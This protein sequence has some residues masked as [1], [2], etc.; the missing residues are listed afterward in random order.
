MAL[1]DEAT[2]KAEIANAAVGITTAFADDTDSGVALEI[3]DPR[4]PLRRV[5]KLIT[6]NEFGEFSPNTDFIDAAYLGKNPSVGSSLDKVAK[7]SEVIPSDFVRQYQLG[8][9]PFVGL[10]NGETQY[11]SDDLPDHSIIAMSYQDA[12]GADEKSL[13]L[14]MGN[15]TTILMDLSNPSNTMTIVSGTAITDQTTYGFM[16]PFTAVQWTIGEPANGTEIGFTVQ[17]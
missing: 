7:A 5:E 1:Q 15:A 14:A 3:A 11:V 2:F 12:D 6:M 16:G 17:P 4:H 8:T 13:V 10:P 9:I